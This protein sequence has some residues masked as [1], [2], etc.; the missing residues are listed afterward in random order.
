MNEPAAYL[1]VATVFVIYIAWLWLDENRKK[2]G[3][4]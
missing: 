2:E 3:D 1:S 4:K